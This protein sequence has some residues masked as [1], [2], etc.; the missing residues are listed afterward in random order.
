[1]TS[2]KRIGLA[3]A[4]VAAVAALAVVPAFGAPPDDRPAPEQGQS[5]SQNQTPGQGQRGRGQGPNATTPATVPATD[6]EK[7]DINRMREEERLAKEL[8]EA[9]GAKW[10]EETFNRIARSEARHAEAMGRVLTRYQLPDPSKDSQVGKFADAELQG[11]WD[12]W[13]A[14]GMESRD[15]AIA[16][17]IELEKADIADLQEAIDRTD[18]ADLD[19]VYGNLKRG[20]E[21]HLAAFE[22]LS[23]GETPTGIGGPNDNAGQGKGNADRQGRGMGS[24]DRQG[25]GMGPGQG[26]G[27]MNPENCPN[28]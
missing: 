5:Q 26:Q 6:A 2:R 16:V 23:R 18:K 15:A 27:Q 11:L 10:G 17:G 13:Y 21:H 28:R 22:A 7:A 8:Y 1:M 25:R 14:R 19:R 24:A 20:S 4:A 9:F 12:D 3:A